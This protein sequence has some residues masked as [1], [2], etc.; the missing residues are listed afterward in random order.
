MVVGDRDGA[1]SKGVPDR[2]DREAVARLLAVWP[3]RALRAKGDGREEGHGPRAR[4]AR[5]G[6]VRMA[7]TRG[8]AKSKAI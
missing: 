5:V 6:H 3:S 2:P 8:R 7:Y 4:G 1:G